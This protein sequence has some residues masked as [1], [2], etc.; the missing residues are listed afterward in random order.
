LAGYQSDSTF[1]RTYH[2]NQ[3][4]KGSIGFTGGGRVLRVKGFVFDSAILVSWSRTF[5]SLSASEITLRWR[6]QA[7]HNDPNYVAGGTV[8]G[9][10]QHTLCADIEEDDVKLSERG[11]KVKIPFPKMAAKKLHGPRLCLYYA[12]RKIGSLYPRW[13]IIWDW[14]LS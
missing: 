8:I 6:A 9:A 13:D 11:R 7:L 5:T 2:A 10:L 3:G 14:Y 1:Q 4:L 12:P